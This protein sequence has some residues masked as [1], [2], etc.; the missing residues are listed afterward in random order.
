MTAQSSS[1]FCRNW[2]N[3]LGAA[4]SNDRFVKRHSALASLKMGFRNTETKESAWI[5]VDENRVTAGTE[6]T[7]AAASFTFLGDTAALEDLRR[8]YPFNRLVRQHRLVVEG[9]MRGCVQNWLL[10]YAI[11]RL[12]SGLEH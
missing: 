6:A 5:S 1:F 9:D 2:L 7:P 4:A 3:A 12:A 11:M 10:I 8:G